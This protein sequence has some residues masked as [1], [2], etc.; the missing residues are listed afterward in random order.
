MTYRTEPP[1]TFPCPGCCN[2]NG[3]SLICR[4]QPG[5]VV[6]D[7]DEGEAWIA[8]RHDA[9]SC[10]RPPTRPCHECKGLGRMPDQV[11]V[12]ARA[13]QLE[14]ALRAYH[15]ACEERLFPIWYEPTAHDLDGQRYRR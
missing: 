6:T 12:G 10:P 3:T 13:W 9:P 11:N 4:E 15:K 1:E 5:L 2:K 7:N 14:D 8:W